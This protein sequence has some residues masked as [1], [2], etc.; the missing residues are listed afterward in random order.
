VVSN[1]VGFKRAQTNSTLLRDL[2]ETLLLL[3]P[4]ELKP[5]RRLLKKK[6]RWISTWPIVVNV[7][8]TMPEPTLN[9]TQVVGQSMARDSLM[10]NVQRTILAKRWRKRVET[11]ILLA[12]KV[13]QAQWVQLKVPL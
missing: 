1:P 4:I 7:K 2:S 6:Q 13:C 11:L 12:L 5:R 8:R 9:G 10:P 3:K